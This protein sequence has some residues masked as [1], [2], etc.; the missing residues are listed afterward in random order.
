ML[1]KRNKRKQELVVDECLGCAD[2]V[3]AK[4]KMEAGGQL[5]WL[6]VEAG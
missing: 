4:Q 1:S 2:E 5:W 6:E 3:I